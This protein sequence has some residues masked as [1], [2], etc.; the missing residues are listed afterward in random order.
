M[1]KGT[2]KE[3]EEDEE[4]RSE[5]REASI[6]G[7][8]EAYRKDLESHLTIHPA[9]Q[10]GP[11]TAKAGPFPLTEDRK[12]LVFDLASSGY[13]SNTIMEIMGVDNGGIDRLE[14]EEYMKEGEFGM[15]RMSQGQGKGEHGSE[16]LLTE[17]GTKLAR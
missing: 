4:T 9:R 2:W 3:E 5:E 8:I 16:R 17:I 13:P 14:L 1:K 7:R 11:G 6:L 12:D 10:E 15:L